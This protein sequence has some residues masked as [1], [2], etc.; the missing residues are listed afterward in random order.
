MPFA[1]T[2]MDLNII[3]LSTVSQKDK[4]HITYMWNLKPDTNELIYKPETDS[5]TQ[6]TDL[7]LPG[8]K[9]GVGEERTG[10]LGL[11]DADYHI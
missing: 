3:I 2:R 11:T 4:Y 8:R 9:W 1:T 5:Q 6:R 7:W 10:S